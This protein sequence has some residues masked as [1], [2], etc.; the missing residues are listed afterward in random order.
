MS[1]FQAA[2]TADERLAGIRLLAKA[3]TD[4]S[5]SWVWNLAQTIEQLCMGTISVAQAMNQTED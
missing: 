5:D 3:L 2:D 1:Q 4:S